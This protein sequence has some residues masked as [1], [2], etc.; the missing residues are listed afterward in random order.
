MAAMGWVAWW[1]LTLAGNETTATAYARQRALPACAFG[2]RGSEEKEESPGYSVDDARGISLALQC[3]EASALPPALRPAAP[4]PAA[5]TPTPSKRPRLAVCVQGAARTFPHVLA[6]GSL[7]AHIIEPFG[8]GSVAYYMHLEV[9]DARGDPTPGRDGLI[10]MD[11]SSVRDAAFAVAG[12]SCAKS[13]DLSKPGVERYVYRN[14]DI[15]IDSRD[16]ADIA[17]ENMALVTCRNDT[18][19]HIKGGRSVNGIDARQLSHVNQLVRFSRCHDFVLAQERQGGQIFNFVFKTRPDM[20]FTRPIQPY[21]LFA[22]MPQSTCWA[23]RDWAHLIGRKAV[24]AW[25]DIWENFRTCK[26]SAAARDLN[27][28]LYIKKHTMRYHTIIDDVHVLGGAMVLRPRAGPFPTNVCSA[29]HIRLYG[30]IFGGRDGLHKDTCKR[31]TAHSP[32]NAMPEGAASRGGVHG[33]MF[34]R[35]RHFGRVHATAG[36]TATIGVRG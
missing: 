13:P 5:V 6:F 31:L 15:A 28:E 10:D 30:H 7:R 20:A 2:D 1:A 35:L 32:L 24:V 3:G 17:A 36:R 23:A 8:A 21:C 18:R 9:H 25:R 26:P 33:S 4:D 11:A 34:D 14:A 29:D 19:F 12:I 22:A 16:V 27:T